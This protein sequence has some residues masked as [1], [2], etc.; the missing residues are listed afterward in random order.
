M[1]CS[2]SFDCGLLVRGAFKRYALHGAEK[3]GVKLEIDEDRS[4]MGS[5]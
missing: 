1:S 5:V 3:F 4:W 2:I